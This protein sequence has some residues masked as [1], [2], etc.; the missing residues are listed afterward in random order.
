MGLNAF[1]LW[2]LGLLRRRPND[3]LITRLVVGAEPSAAVAVATSTL[4]SV[5]SSEPN[6]CR[7]DANGELNGAEAAANGDVIKVMPVDVWLLRGVP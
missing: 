7:G 5:S 1:S 2:D 4:S 6:T 3:L